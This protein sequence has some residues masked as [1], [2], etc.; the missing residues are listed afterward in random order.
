MSERNDG[1]PAFPSDRFDIQIR[2]NVSQYGMSL[3]DYFAA[4]AMTGLLSYVSI[5]DW[6]NAKFIRSS[7][8]AHTAYDIADTM[9]AKRS[10]DRQESTEQPAG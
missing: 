4:A 10:K 9:L 7:M 1:G 8:Y 5:D 6:R 3:R 2:A